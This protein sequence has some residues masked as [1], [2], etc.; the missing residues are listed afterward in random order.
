MERKPP[1]KLSGLMS[2]AG[3]MSRRWSGS[4]ILKI[5]PSCS[6]SVAVLIL[7]NLTGKRFCWFC[8]PD[9]GC[10]AVYRVKVSFVNRHGN[11]FAWTFVE[12]AANDREA[13]SEGVRVFFEGLTM[14]EREDAVNTLSVEARPVES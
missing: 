3:I 6:A 10:R 8:L 12:E 11:P 1:V 14:D 4:P 2:P 5:C 9:E 7:D 13:M